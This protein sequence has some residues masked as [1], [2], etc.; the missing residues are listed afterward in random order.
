VPAELHIFET[1]PHGYGTAPGNPLLSQWLGLAETWMRH[2][3]LL[4]AAAR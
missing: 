4:G 2:R 1:G 3:G